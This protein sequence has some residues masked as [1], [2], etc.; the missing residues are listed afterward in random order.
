VWDRRMAVGSAQDQAATRPPADIEEAECVK[1]MHENG[2]QEV[3]QRK[4]SR[5]MMI[6]AFLLVCMAGVAL[7]AAAGMG[8][9]E[10]PRPESELLSQADDA[11]QSSKLHAIAAAL[12]KRNAILNARRQ[13]KPAASNDVVSTMM[14]AQ[15]HAVQR[16]AAKLASAP[17]TMT[18][19]KMLDEEPAA[20]EPV[21]EEPASE[22]PASEAPAE[23]PAAADTS[24]ESKIKDTSDDAMASEIG[25]LKP[26]GIMGV[27]FQGHTLLMALGIIVTLLLA[28]C[29]FARN[30]DC[31]LT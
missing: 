31:A 10:R 14:A 13:T 24:D 3:P 20:E 5:Q 25:N 8:Q 22:E 26:T 7:V 23:A 19:G 15:A 12:H 18:R 30:C 16:S 9:I 4:M 1:E 2:V 29:L 17:K 27:F 28:I 21:A 11:L 6:S